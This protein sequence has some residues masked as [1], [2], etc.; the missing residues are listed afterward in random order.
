M[1]IPSLRHRPSRKFH[2][3]RWAVAIHALALISIWHGRAWAQDADAGSGGEPSLLV[4][5]M[6]AAILV[7]VAV[8]GLLALQLGKLRSSR[9]KRSAE[10]TRSG[11]DGAEPTS[12]ETS[13]AEEQAQTIE[14]SKKVIQDLLLN[15]SEMV[16]DLIEQQ[17]SY[18]GRMEDHKAEIQKIT[19][20]AKLRETVKIII[21]ELDEIHAA[22]ERYR[23]QLNEAHDKIQTQQELMDEIQTAAKID[24]LTKIAN[25]RAFD[26]RLAEEFARGKR[27]DHPFALAL[28]DI[29]HFKAINDKHGHVAG[30]KMLQLVAMRM[31]Q[32]VRLT[33]FVARYGG[34]EFAI[35]LP[36]SSA[37]QALLVAQ[38]VREAVK[39]AGLRHDQMTLRVTISAGVGE[40]NPKRDTPEMLTKRVDAAL[41]RAKQSGRNRVEKAEPPP[42]FRGG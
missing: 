11:G 22:G 39:Q 2:P 13:K 14:S 23:D 5:G 35:L 20:V 6:A 42:L 29:D 38:K 37:E 12:A 3:I 4:V 25:R 1:R 40:M 17:S 15:L 18:S 30:D 19:T 16:N 32:Q 24:F 31:E 41:Y 33:D 8:I 10:D 26:E 27:Y 34:E 21:R 7:L 36:E 9:G 28:L